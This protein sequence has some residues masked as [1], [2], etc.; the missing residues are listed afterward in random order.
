[1]N[2]NYFTLNEYLSNKITGCKEQRNLCWL[3]T[4][5]SPGAKRFES[6]N[7]YITLLCN[8]V[9]WYGNKEL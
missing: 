8:K 9:I 4:Q 2:C 6:S 1:M 7:A 5:R 3:Q